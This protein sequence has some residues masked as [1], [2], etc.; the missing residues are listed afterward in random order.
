VSAQATGSV[1]VRRAQ[2]RT[3][4][5]NDTLHRATDLH[6]APALRKRAYPIPSN[7]RAVLLLAFACVCAP[8]GSC[9]RV[10]LRPSCCLFISAFI[11]L[12]V[13]CLL[14]PLLPVIARRPPPSRSQTPR[15]RVRPPPKATSSTVSD[16]QSSRRYKRLL[17]C[18]WTGLVPSAHQ[19]RRSTG[20]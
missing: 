16:A 11:C 14:A 7:V 10:C 8:V 5:L 17:L 4:L 19:P 1:D 20:V 6:S 12:R 18:A 2:T 3:R 9:V 15:V 13:S